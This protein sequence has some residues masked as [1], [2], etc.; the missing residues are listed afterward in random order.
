[1]RLTPTKQ[2]A[3]ALAFGSLMICG[4]LHAPARG[5]PAQQG[6][7]NFGKISE[8]LYRGAEPDATAIT[9]LSQLGIKAIIDLRIGDEV[10]SKEATEAQAAGILYTN[11]P[12]HGVGRPADDQIRQV[13]S[14]LEKMPG[15]VFIHCRH[16]CDRTGTVVACYRI[17]HDQWSND[18]AMKEALH[19]GISYFERGMRKFIL[20]FKS[21]APVVSPAPAVPLAEK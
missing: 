5:L 17:Q 13:L 19:Y 9:N 12:L 14:L 18:A 10:W 21:L 3:L 6:I 15:P 7:L 11:I 8:K 16:G 2:T 20:A 1:M 4:A